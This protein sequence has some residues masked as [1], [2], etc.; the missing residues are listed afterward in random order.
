MPRIESRISSFL[1][2]ARRCGSGALS[3]WG[4]ADVPC[5]NPTR[6]SR[7]TSDCTRCLNS[8]GRILPSRRSTAA[9]RSL[10][11]SRKRGAAASCAGANDFRS[12]TGNS[13][14]TGDDPG[15]RDPSRMATRGHT[16]LSASLN[17][18]LSTRIRPASRALLPQ[19]KSPIASSR[20]GGADDSGGS[21]A[22][23]RIRSRT[24]LGRA[25]VPLRVRCAA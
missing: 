13:A 18:F 1:G 24:S 3:T 20:S 19:E 17:E 11:R 16:V 15:D 25:I 5:S 9:V 23:K 12:W 21:S 22:P 7:K 4:G 14:S 10:T 8:S 6:A 2:S